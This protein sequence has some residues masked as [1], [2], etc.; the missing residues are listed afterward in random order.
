M[1]GKPMAR[2]ESETDEYVPERAYLLEQ[3]EPLRDLAGDILAGDHS[4][5]HSDLRKAKELAKYGDNE[6]HR[7]LGQ[8]I[9]T[10]LSA[11]TELEE[12]SDVE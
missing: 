8:A 5:H 10:F 1:K 3:V 2:Y 9:L 4:V 7:R 6:G 12:A 11:V